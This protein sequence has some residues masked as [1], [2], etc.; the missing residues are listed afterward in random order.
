MLS[1]LRLSNSRLLAY[2]IEI[3]Q[4]D[5]SLRVFSLLDKMLADTVVAVFSEP[6]LF[7]REFLEFALLLPETPTHCRRFWE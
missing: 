5:T 7:T 4:C 6:L 1:S 2:P 3:F